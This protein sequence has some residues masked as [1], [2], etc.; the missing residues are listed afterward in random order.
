ICIDPKRAAACARVIEPLSALGKRHVASLM[1]EFCRNLSA[2]VTDHLGDAYGRWQTLIARLRGDEPIRDLPD[3]LRV[4]YLAGGL[5]ASGIMAS[6]RDDP[7]ALQVADELDALELKLYEMSADQ[8]RVM[9]YGNQ[10]DRELFDHYREQVEMHAMQ[11]G[12]AWQAETWAAAAQLTVYLR[13]HDGMRM[14]QCLQQLERVALDVPSLAGYVRRAHGIYLLLRGKAREALPWLEDALNEEPLSV[15]GWARACGTLARAYHQLGNHARAKEICVETLAR[16]SDEDLSFPAM[17]LIVPLELAVA[18]AGLGQVDE[19]KRIL[20]RWL[21]AHRAGG[22]LTLGALHET[23]VRIALSAQDESLFSEQFAAMERAYR[24]SRAPSLVEYCE[25]L[26]KK[27]RRLLPAFGESAELRGQE[28]GAHLNTVLYRIRHGGSGS[29]VERARWALSQVAPYIRLTEG[30]VY[31]CHTGAVQRIAD[32]TTEPA[33]SGPVR[34]SLPSEVLS[35]LDTWVTQRLEARSELQ[36][37]TAVADDLASL[38][39]INELTLDGR[40]YRL[41]FLQALEASA[42]VVVGGLVV[43]VEIADL[44]PHTVLEAVASRFRT[45]STH[46]SEPPLSH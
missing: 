6:W 31:L 8:I 46:T 5:Y 30:Y 19:A 4:F 36:T 34:K 39:N 16:L 41:I 10:G 43:P 7:R 35:E 2:T 18:E 33:E 29:L 27:Q 37:K 40:S 11:R 9:Y 15:V 13:M 22:P 26:A 24:G 23:G 32:L 38:Q 21:A 25:R 20:Y 42:E 3:G 44:I 1:H 28:L 12:T 14:K 17:T 45:L